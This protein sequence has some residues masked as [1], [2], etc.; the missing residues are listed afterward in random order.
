MVQI[1][2][3]N[4][5]GKQILMDVKNIHCDKLKLV[6][7]IKPF[8]DNVVEELKLNVVGECSHQFKKDNCPYGVTMVYL[9]AESHLSIHT[10]VDEG[11]ITLDLF[12]CD[13][14]LEDRNFKKIVSDYFDVSFLNIDAYY[15]TRGT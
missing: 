7:D 1:Y 2:N 14:S 15:F 13:I 12:T 8:M 5:V 3:P 11:K 4:T 9:L 10:F 6:D